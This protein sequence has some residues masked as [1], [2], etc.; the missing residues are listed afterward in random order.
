[1]SDYLLSYSNNKSA[2]GEDKKSWIHY[3]E[4]GIGTPEGTIVRF[5]TNYDDNYNS[6]INSYWN[7]YPLNWNA[8]FS[9]N[10]DK[11]G[12]LMRPTFYV[13][14]NVNIIGNGTNDNPYIINF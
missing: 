4:K 7:I 11:D 1:M 12:L 14:N 5:S 9:A 10:W 3:G 13:S 2:D 6:W 8:S